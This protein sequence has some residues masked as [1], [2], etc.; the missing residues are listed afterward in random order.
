LQAFQQEAVIL[1]GLNHPG[2]TAV[3]DYFVENGSFYLVMEFVQ[4]E[5]LQQAWE[6]AGRRFNETQVVA[7]AQQLCEV[8]TYLHRQQPPIVFRDLKPANIMLQPDGRLKLIDFGIARQ[9]DPSKTSDTVKF[10]TPGYAAPEQ[11]GRGQ[12]DARSDLY[13]LGIVLHQ[14]LSGCEP[15]ITPFSLPDI[16]TFS[17]FVSPQV[18]HAIRQATQMDMARRPPTA[19]VFCAALQSGAP[20]IKIK[21][22]RA[23]S[24]AW[25]ATGGLLLLLLILMGIGQLRNSSRDNN[26]LA[27]VSTVSHTQLS[28]IPVVTAT[29]VTAVPPTW[30]LTTISVPPPTS[31]SLAAVNVSVS[32]SSTPS[33]SP[34]TS[35]PPSPTSPPSP[36]TSTPTMTLPP[37][38]PVAAVAVTAYLPT[39]SQAENV[40]SVW[41]RVSFE[42]MQSPG[43]RRYA[44]TVHSN[45]TLRWSFA[46]CAKSAAGLQEI[47]VPL[48]FSFLLQGQA[49]SSQQLLQHDKVT[50]DNW[51]CRYWSTLLTNWEN[52]QRVELEI[53]YQ[54]TSSIYDGRRRYDP[55]NYRQII[56]VSVR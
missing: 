51:H 49:L 13:A 43:T 54:L 41:S 10:G 20:T 29:A 32:P 50:P 36:P 53:Q 5:T 12:T 7:W 25:G 14:L 38:I 9:F 22:T 33:P 18:V 31:T 48:T 1:A 15:T 47:L 39:L 42:D 56:S 52:G 24:W 19:Q 8:L 45:E 26:M 4:G 16:G 23:P 17:T 28:P 30:T 35:T 55:G 27:V 44:I 40:P 3:H 6:R 2:L 34:P 21:T 37:T 11:Y 46:W